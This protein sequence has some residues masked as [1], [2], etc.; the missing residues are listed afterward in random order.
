M[1]ASDGRQTRRRSSLY[2]GTAGL[3]LCR[4]L[5]LAAVVAA[6]LSAFAVAG[7]SYRLA[8]L[9]SNDDTDSQPTG[10][11]AQSSGRA[12]A[13][14][15]VSGPAE[16]DLAYA[17]A[18]AADVLARGG[19]DSSVPWQNPRTGAGGNITP[20]ATSYREGGLPCRDFLASYVHGAMQDWL[21]GAACRSASGTWEVTRLK[22]L[23]PS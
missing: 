7:C 11:I 18:A 10:A 20:L 12:A 3:R 15:G 6:A 9:V 8:S 1:L 17:R 2:N 4:R 21:Q 5:R 16:V 22:P 14:G 23:K 13:D 19:K